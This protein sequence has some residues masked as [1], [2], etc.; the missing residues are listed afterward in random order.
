M[1]DNK[2]ENQVREFYDNKGWVADNNGKLNENVLFRD[3]KGGKGAY[4][5]KISTK[6]SRILEGRSGTLLI[7]G[8][9]DLPDSHISA[10]D[11]F[12]KVICLDISERALE[13]SKRKL[14]DKGEYLKASA[15]GMPLPDNSID[16]VLCAHMLYHVDRSK[17]ETAVR[18]MIR[19]TKHGGR[20][21]IIYS[22]PEAPLML[23]QRF[24]KVL[25]INK[26]LGKAY[27]YVYNYPLKWWESFSKS[28]AVTFLPNDAISANQVKV[29]FP[30]VGLRRKFYQWAST[31]EDAHP[32]CAV[33]LWSYVTVIM[34]KHF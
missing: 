14:G 28:C 5:K 32:D 17:Q 21:L 23:V 27:L 33:T 29:L 13:F 4:E 7:V 8:G 15:L 12:E 9:G 30:T 16:A 2:V 24:L 20:I 19:V 26:L 10:A 34:D 25:H 22:N 31:F 3:V 6:P 1:S 11:G 18:E